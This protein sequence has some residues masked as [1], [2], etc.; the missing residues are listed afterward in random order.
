MKKSN[1]LAKKKKLLQI[2]LNSIKTKVVIKFL[3]KLFITA[4]NR[5]DTERVNVSLGPSR[6]IN[7]LC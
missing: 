3:K 2:Y 7:L 6:D 4:E 1:Q 5:L